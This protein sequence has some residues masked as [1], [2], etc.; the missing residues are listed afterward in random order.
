ME[1]DWANL[2]ANPLSIILDKLIERIDHVW[3]SAVCKNW[4]SV[5]KLNHQSQQ[6]RTNVLPMLTFRSKRGLYSIPSHRF[7]I[8]QSKMPYG[9]KICGSSHGWVAI[10]ESNLTITL[11]NPFK[12]VAP[13]P[14]PPLHKFYISQTHKVTLSADPITSPND[15]VVVAISNRE[16]CIPFMRAGQTDW[17]Y[18]H[19]TNP[20]YADIIFYKGLVY[21]AQNNI[22]SFFNLDHSGNKIINDASLG[23][24]DELGA[25][26]V[27]IYLVKSLEG[28]L[29]MVR[30]LY[31]ANNTKGFQVYKLELD[32]QSGKLVG[33]VKLES[34]GDD[35][36]FIGGCDSISV[37]ASCFSRCL[38]KDSIY[39]CSDYNDKAYDPRGPFDSGVYNV[40]DGSFDQQHFPCDPSFKCTLP[41]FWVLPPFQWD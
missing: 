4:C 1:A 31:I 10:C 24:V 28:D 19:T 40:K 33:K 20:P 22:V 21:V 17:G 8:F 15:Y 7:Y 6:F 38:Q 9:K 25:C 32:A 30:R 36:L 41:S 26:Y 29:W 35:V 14:L 39:Y 13:I 18:V 16:C 27:K 2:E 11:F 34:L 12:N 5:A 23:S 3:F 37:S